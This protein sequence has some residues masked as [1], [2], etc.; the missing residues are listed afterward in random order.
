MKFLEGNLWIIFSKIFFCCCQ[1]FLSFFFLS[2]IIQIYLGQNVRVFFEYLLI[3]SDQFVSEKVYKCTKLSLFLYCI[4]WLEDMTTKLKKYR[5][6]LRLTYYSIHWRR[7]PNLIKIE[8]PF[9]YHDFDRRF[10]R[11]SDITTSFYQWF[12]ASDKN[13]IWICP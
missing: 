4:K 9:R 12:Q 8:R 11:V 7:R 6:N 5:Q 2:W 10:L 3:S 1:Q 13:R